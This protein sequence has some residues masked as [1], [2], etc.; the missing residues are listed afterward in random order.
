MVC[1]EIMANLFGKIMSY[2]KRLLSGVVLSAISGGITKA[3]HL[4]GRVAHMIAIVTG[5]DIDP[6]GILIAVSGIFGLIGLIFWPRIESR[7]LVSKQFAITATPPDS[8]IIESPST[9][10]LQDNKT[11]SRYMSAYEAISYIAKE[12]EWGFLIRNTVSDEGM[13]KMPMLE[14]PIAFRKAARE[15]KITVLGR[16]NDKGTHISIPADEWESIQLDMLNI[17]GNITTPAVPNREDVPFYT[18]IQVLREEVYTAF[19]KKPSLESS[20][21]IVAKGDNMEIA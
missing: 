13:R 10:L 21:I 6:L 12:S 18:Y 11:E 19:P 7:F 16:K 9:P 15:G 2:F 8:P 20:E 5:L 4:D 1:Q 3:F 17:Q 14:A